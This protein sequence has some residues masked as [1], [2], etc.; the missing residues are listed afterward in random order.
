MKQNTSRSEK[1]TERATERA[2]EYG[3][4]MDNSWEKK[5]NQQWKRVER[6]R[7]VVIHGWIVLMIF[8]HL[9]RTQQMCR[10]VQTFMVFLFVLSLSSVYVA[11]KI[12]FTISIQFFFYVCRYN[13]ACLM[14]FW[15]FKIDYESI[16]LNYLCSWF[17]TDR[18][19]FQLNFS[20][21]RS[22]EKITL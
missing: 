15:C 10:F 16:K 4:G 13:C 3:Y 6:L 18:Y 21:L 11:F 20:I 19:T 8:C 9:E 2:T 17:S 12:S 22:Y 5:K 14:R 7:L 1:E